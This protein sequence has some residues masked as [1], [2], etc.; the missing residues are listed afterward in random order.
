MIHEPMTLLTDILLSGWAFFLGGKLLSRAFNIFRRYW[1]LGLIATGCAALLGGIWHGFSPAWEACAVDTVWKFVLL[2]I[3]TADALFGLGAVDGATQGLLRRWLRGLVMAKGC[4]FLVLLIWFDGFWLAVA[5]YVPTLL[6][7][8]SLQVR[9][10]PRSLAA[11]WMVAGV[12]SALVAAAVQAS[13][14]SLHQWFNHND[15][16]HLIQGFALYA[17]FLSVRLNDA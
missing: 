12:V 9:E 5:D 7:I 4:M 14:L 3:G 17:F 10:L 15:I 16:Y 8:L 11:R 2:L 6:L 1:G 13:G